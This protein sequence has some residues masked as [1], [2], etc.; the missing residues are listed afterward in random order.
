[1]SP[2]I[3]GLAALPDFDVRA[4]ATYFADVDRAEDRLPYVSGVV[5]LAMSSALAKEGERFD[6]ECPGRC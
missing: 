3:Q 4:I 6:R 1:M 5:S 2:V